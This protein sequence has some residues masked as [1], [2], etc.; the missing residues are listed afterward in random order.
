MKRKKKPVTRI[1]LPKDLVDEVNGMLAPRGTDVQT[2]L[3]LQL[4]AFRRAKNILELADKMPFGK[5]QG[6]I[7]EDVVRADPG[8][9]NWLLV[10]HDKVQFAP[11]VTALIEEL[12]KA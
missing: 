12:D 7:I 3:R 2:Y 9:V 4:R 6:E 10:N 11:E 5:Y 8:Y 1:S